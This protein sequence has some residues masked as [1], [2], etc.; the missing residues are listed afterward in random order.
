MI[1]TFKHNC[2][3]LV[4][5]F[6]GV[7]LYEHAGGVNGE[8]VV[9]GYACLQICVTLLGVVLSLLQQNLT[10]V[11]EVNDYLIRWISTTSEWLK[12]KTNSLL[13]LE[14]EQ[15]HISELLSDSSSPTSHVRRV[16]HASPSLAKS[17][18]VHWSWIWSLDRRLD[19]QPSSLKG[20]I[21]QR[22]S[23]C[24]FSAQ[25]CREEIRTKNISPPKNDIFKGE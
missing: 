3:T 25:A 2:Q 8:L 11:A 19:P 5:P 16:T 4:E 14:Q 13:C 1:C 20:T 6:C 17:Q 24:V 22:S 18:W 7:W 15:W 9:E 21:N 23:A 10:L 12:K